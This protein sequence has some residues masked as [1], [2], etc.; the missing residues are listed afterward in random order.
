[1]PNLSSNIPNSPG[2]EPNLPGNVPNLQENMPNLPNNIPNPPGDEPNPLIPNLVSNLPKLSGKLPGLLNN[3][4][5]LPNKI[6]LS[7]NIKIP[8]SIPKL[9][10]KIPDFLS[11]IPKLSG[12][13]PNILNKIPNIPEME[14]KSNGK[15]KDSITWEGG[16]PSK[17]PKQS[18]A[19]QEMMVKD[20]EALE[21]ETETSE[22]LNSIE[23][24]SE[25]EN[26]DIGQLSPHAAVE[27]LPSPPSSIASSEFQ[28][29]MKYRNAKTLNLPAE[30]ITHNGKDWEVV[31]NPE[32]NGEFIVSPIL[33]EVDVENTNTN[34]KDIKKANPYLNEIND[35]KLEVDDDKKA[36]VK[37]LITF[38]PS[39]FFFL[40]IK[41]LALY[42]M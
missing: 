32:I 1:M 26:E 33:N 27:P 12:K 13:I 23:E 39:F 21:L 41:F 34:E 5:K 31:D 3:L 38:F 9:L 17:I 37:Y 22:T 7:G 14:V 25:I 2:N 35:E 36:M 16:L 20:N 11:N 28:K 18:E 30:T 10:G 24:I 4:P 40:S 42:I 29:D 8:R 15:K 19:M 6:K